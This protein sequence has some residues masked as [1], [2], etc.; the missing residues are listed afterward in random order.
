[1]PNLMWF[2]FVVLSFNI[3]SKRTC[4]AC[5]YSTMINTDFYSLSFIHFH[6]FSLLHMPWRHH[7]KYLSIVRSVAWFPLILF[8]NSMQVIT[9]PCQALHLMPMNMFIILME[10]AANTNQN[11]KKPHQGLTKATNS[12]VSQ[13]ETVFHHNL[14]RALQLLRFHA[15]NVNLHILASEYVLI[16]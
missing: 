3:M 4:R 7:H 8:P 15:T 14:V 1:M 9:F 11:I 10:S 2:Q 13:T 6:S 16:F 12:Y 5:N